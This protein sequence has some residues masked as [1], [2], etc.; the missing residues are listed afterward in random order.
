MTFERTSDYGL[1]GALIR[2]PSLYPFFADDFSPPVEE[3][4]AIENPGLWYILARDGEEVLGFWMFVPQ[5]F[6]CWDLHTVMP[7]DGLALAAMRELLGP[8]GWLWNNTPCLRVVTS[9]PAWNRIAHRFGLRAGLKEYGRNP[10]SY[11]K[12]GELYDQIL[13]GVSKP[14]D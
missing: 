13:M 6:I 2:N 3:A 4:V 12:D 9:V 14:K 11:F 8:G 1:L 5:N 7:L 10:D